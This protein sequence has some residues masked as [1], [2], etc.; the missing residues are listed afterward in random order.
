M[1]DKQTQTY[2]QLLYLFLIIFIFGSFISK[3]NTYFI[4]M[5]AMIEFRY[6]FFKW[7][8]S[9]VVWVKFIQQIKNIQMALS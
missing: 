7:S 1:G 2:I 5:C 3:Y 8:I 9:S 4:S 6:S